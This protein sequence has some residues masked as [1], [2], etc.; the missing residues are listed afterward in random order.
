MVTNRD[1][2]YVHFNQERQVYFLGAKEGC[3]IFIRAGAR[4]WIEYR[5]N[6]KYWIIEPIVYPNRKRN[7]GE[8]KE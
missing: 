2:T 8:V 7:I 3:Q 4:E 6:P 1:R 5:S